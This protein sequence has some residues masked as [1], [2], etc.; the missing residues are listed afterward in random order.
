MA[1][2]VRIAGQSFL[3]RSR[4]WM[5]WQHRKVLLAIARCRTAAL[6]GH[7]DQCSRCG[8]SAISYN[9]CR[10]RHCLG[11]A[12]TLLAK[13]V[14]FALVAQMVVSK[15]SLNRGNH[16]VIGDA[17]LHEGIAAALTGGEEM[18]ARSGRLSL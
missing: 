4:Q 2:L 6:G 11:N 18:C 14:A 8:H 9:S 17:I 16:P 12:R 5:T 1:D 3:E 13:T 10:N 7:R 15:G